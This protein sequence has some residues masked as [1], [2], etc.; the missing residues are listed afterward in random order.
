VRTYERVER[1]FNAVFV[2][3]GQI[4]IAI[5][6]ALMAVVVVDVFLRK[7]FNKPIYGST[8]IVQYLTL[9]QFVVALIW[10]T[11]V[12]EHIKV[13]LLEKYIPSRVK[14]VLSSFFLVLCLGFYALIG[15]QNWLQATDASTGTW[16]SVVLHI[17]YSPFYLVLAIS[18][19]CTTLII[20][21]ILIK[22][23]LQGVSHA[24]KS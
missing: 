2:R 5:I 11:M 22:N 24:P 12:D 19:F 16:K 4:S 13:D 17:P 14:Y 8:E 7:V 21:M 18:V 15:W 1:Y 23:I 6:L 3:I 9:S 10:T 20:L